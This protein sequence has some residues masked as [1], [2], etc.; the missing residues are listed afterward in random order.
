[1]YSKIKTTRKIEKQTNTTKWH[2]KKNIKTL[3]YGVI[4]SCGTVAFFLFFCFFVTIDHKIYGSPASVIVNALYGQWVCV[5]YK[6]KILVN[7][8]WILK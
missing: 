7:E 1:M 4:V 5:K 2:H 8:I 6:K 3:H